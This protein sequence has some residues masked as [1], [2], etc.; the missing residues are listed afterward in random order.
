[1]ET[2]IFELSL[3]MVLGENITDEQRLRVQKRNAKYELV[4]FLVLEKLGT[5]VKNFHFDTGSAF[6]TTSTID[7]VNQLLESH[8]VILPTTFNDSNKSHRFSAS[9]PPIAQAPS[10]SR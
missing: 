7:I 9:Q 2:D 4:R 8:N 6:E 3:K 10:T 1:M 5:A